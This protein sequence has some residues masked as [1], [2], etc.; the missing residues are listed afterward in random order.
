PLPVPPPSVPKRVPVSSTA[1]LSTHR[2]GEFAV[3]CSARD[4]Y[5]DIPGSSRPRRG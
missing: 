5:F 4:A 2:T 3:L 1:R